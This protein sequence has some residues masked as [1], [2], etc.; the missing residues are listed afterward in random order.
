[1]GFEEPGKP[2]RASAFCPWS[3]AIGPTSLNFRTQSAQRIPGALHSGNRAPP[4]KCRD[5]AGLGNRRTSASAIALLTPQ[6]APPSQQSS[7]SSYSALRRIAPASSRQ[8]PDCGGPKFQ[9]MRR[10]CRSHLEL[11][12]GVHI[13]QSAMLSAPP[14]QREEPSGAPRAIS[15]SLFHPVRCEVLDIDFRHEARA[16]CIPDHIHSAPPP[17]TLRHIA[18][19]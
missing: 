18:P 8:R 12:L 7:R 14:F 19:P 15:P 11:H 9:L 3:S 2:A 5:A 4:V 6:P 1:M 16:R 17:W 10:N 13:R